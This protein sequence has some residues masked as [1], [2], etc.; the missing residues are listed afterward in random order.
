MCTRL[1]RIAGDANWFGLRRDF[2]T[3]LEQTRAGK[4]TLDGWQAFEAE[5]ARLTAAEENQ[6]IRHSDI[7][8]DLLVAYGLAKAHRCPR[9]LCDRVVRAAPGEQPGCQLFGVPMPEET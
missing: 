8:G 6:T 3:L 1:R 2:D 4:D 9:A 5:V 7:D